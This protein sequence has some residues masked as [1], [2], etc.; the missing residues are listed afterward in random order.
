MIRNAPCILT[1]HLS[2]ALCNCKHKNRFL[3]WQCNQCDLLSNVRTLMLHLLTELTYSRNFSLVSNIICRSH[4]SSAVLQNTKMTF[5]SL[6]MNLFAP[7]IKVAWHTSDITH[8]RNASAT[9]T[10]TAL[11]PT[12]TSSADAGV[13][14]SSSNTAVIAA[15]ALG[16]VAA[17]AIVAVITLLFWRRRTKWSKLPKYGDLGAHKVYLS[18]EGKRHAELPDEACL[19]ESEA[20]DKPKEDAEQRAPAELDSDWTGWEAPALLDIDFLNLGREQTSVEGST[21]IQ[22]CRSS[23]QQMSVDVVARR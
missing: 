14:R 1:G 23:T 9:S 15:I 2:G 17:V 4:C 13:S 8:W 19:H 7:T 18:G 5:S 10:P 11:V 20:Q 21:T 16:F 12:P 22:G 6:V 3:C